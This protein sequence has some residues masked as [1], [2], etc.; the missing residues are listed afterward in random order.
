MNCRISH[1]L[2]IPFYTSP[3]YLCFI[4]L[5]VMD[6]DVD[7]DGI[8]VDLGGSITQKRT[9]VQVTIKWSYPSSNGISFIIIMYMY[10]RVIIEFL[11]DQIALTRLLLQNAENI[12]RM[13]TVKTRTILC[14]KSG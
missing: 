14:F 4:A 7:L 2:R 10:M 11:F 12:K 3:Q 6:I 1:L 8:D 13:E 5:D 9:K